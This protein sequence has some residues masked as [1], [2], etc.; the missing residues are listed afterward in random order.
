MKLHN[1]LLAAVGALALGATG[2]VGDLEPVE[3]NTP[4]SGSPDAGVTDPPDSPDAGT[5]IPPDDTSEA[6][7]L[8]EQNVYP[9]IVANCGGAACH[10]TVSPAFVGDSLDTAY[11]TANLHKDLLFLGYDP[12]NSKLI[13]NGAGAHKGVT[14]SATDLQ[15]IEAWFAAEKASGGGGTQGASPL[16]IWS[17]CMDLADWNLEEVAPGWSNKQAQGQGN[18]EACHN[19]GADGFIASDQSQRVFDAVSQSPSFMLSY[20]TLND[21]GTEVIINRARL[22]NVGN[23]LPPHQEHGAFDVDGDAMQRLQRF[24]DRTMARKAAGICQPPRFPQ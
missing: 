3:N 23:R 15:A 24:Y 22:E 16:A 19:L 11:A 5:V 14:Y 10:G 9:I 4:P 18:C 12:A 17:G 13:D 7:A 6:Q 1:T 21:T 20:F 8:F 2:C